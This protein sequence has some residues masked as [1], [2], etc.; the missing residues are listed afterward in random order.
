LR[1]YKLAAECVGHAR[2][3]VPDVV[4]D[5]LYVGQVANCLTQVPQCMCMCVCGPGAVW[6][7]LSVSQCIV[8]MACSVNDTDAPGDQI[9]SSVNDASADRAVLRI[10]RQSSRILQLLF[11]FFQ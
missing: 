3:Q 6:S 10:A 2:G 7:G 5:V 11:V 1:Q 8:K 4:T 9:W